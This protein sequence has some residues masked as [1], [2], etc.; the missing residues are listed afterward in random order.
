MHMP[1]P[2]GRRNRTPFSGL[3]IG[4]RNALKDR[5]NKKMPLLNIVVGPIVV[6]VGLSLINRYIPMASPF[7]DANRPGSKVSQGLRDSFWLQGMWCGH[8]AAYDRIKAFSETDF[9]EDLKKL[10]V[11][12]LVLHGHDDQIFPIADSALLSA[13][14]VKRATLKVIH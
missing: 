3:R 8:K 11:P 1:H 2:P 14:L 4:Q 12:T 9:T 13:K 5:R 6:G 7:Y 10:D